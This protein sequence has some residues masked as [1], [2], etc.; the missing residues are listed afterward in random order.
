MTILPAVFAR[1]GVLPVPRIKY[2]HP[3]FDLVVENI[4][5]GASSR[6]S[7]CDTC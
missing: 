3:D 4:A 1:V 5:I 6:T 7:G 2:T